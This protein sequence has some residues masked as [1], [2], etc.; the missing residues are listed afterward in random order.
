MVYRRKISNHLSLEDEDVGVIYV[1]FIDL[2]TLVDWNDKP[3]QC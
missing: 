2:K 3:L 1:K